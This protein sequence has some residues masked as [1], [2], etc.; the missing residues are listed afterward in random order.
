VLEPIE[1]MAL[2]APRQMA[3]GERYVIYAGLDNLPPNATARVQLCRE[4]ACVFDRLTALEQQRTWWGW[5]GAVRLEPGRYQG[6]LFIQLS[7]PTTTLRTVA[8]F[9]W[10][11]DVEE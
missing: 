8:R 9:S 6:H 4:G 3:A 5:L 7:H 11:V 2:M 1:L 10:D